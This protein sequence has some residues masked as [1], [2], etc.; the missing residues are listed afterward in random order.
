M[1]INSYVLG[2][3]TVIGFAALALIL[4]AIFAPTTK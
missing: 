4:A 3:L 2:I 1:Y